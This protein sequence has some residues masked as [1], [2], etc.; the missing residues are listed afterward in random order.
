MA[1]SCDKDHGIIYPEPSGNDNTSNTFAPEPEEVG[2]RVVAHRGGAMESGF[3]DNSIAG[4]KYSISLDCYA[5]ECDI[6]LTEDEKVV[7]AHATDGC[8]INGVTPWDHTL[9]ELREAGKLDNG[10]KLPDLGDFIDVVLKAGT[11]RLWLDVKLI[12]ENGKTTHTS[13]SIKACQKACEIIANKKAQNFC[14]FIVTSNSTVWH[15]CYGVAQ[16]AG[17]KVGWM[18]YRNPDDYQAF[19][20]PWANLSTENI[21]SQGTDRG[22]KWSVSDYLDANVQLSFYNVDTDADRAYY[23]KYYDRLYALC[24]NYPSKMFDAISKLK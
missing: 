24:T 13:E 1:C 2:N 3:P 15:G 21:Y 11:T 12:K 9:A 19:F 16:G 4:L 5:S 17:I 23:L 10:E 22:G 6:Y 18:S 8:F 7:V 14:E 20:N